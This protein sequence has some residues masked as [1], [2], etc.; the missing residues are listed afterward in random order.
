MATLI[1][2]MPITSKAL[3]SGPAGEKS[4]SNSSTHREECD[5]S[6]PWITNPL[7]WSPS[8]L[9][10]DP[11]QRSGR[12]VIVPAG[13]AGRDVL[14]LVPLWCARSRAKSERCRHRE[15]RHGIPPRR[16][17]RRLV[18]RLAAP[19]GAWQSLH[20]RGRLPTDSPL[21]RWRG[22][23]SPLLRDGPAPAVGGD[24]AA[25]AVRVAAFP[26]GD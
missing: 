2:A 7:A 6:R 20:S 9:D 5:P 1:A 23:A 19:R 21:R 25:R 11:S 13:Y 4:H 12:C 24:R 22:L 26:A 18:F 8:A 16:A 3:A 15:E 10:L 14:G 17:P